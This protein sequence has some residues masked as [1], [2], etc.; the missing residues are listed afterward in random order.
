MAVREQ[1]YTRDLAETVEMYVSSRL[2]AERPVSTADAIRAI[3]TALPKCDL[4]DRALT[5]MVAGSAIRHRQNVIFDSFEDAT[6]DTDA[7]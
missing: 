7:Q 1:L 2:G 6:R 4:D 5:D 3:R